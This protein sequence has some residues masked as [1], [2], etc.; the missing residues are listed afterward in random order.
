SVSSITSAEL[1]DPATGIW[2]DTGSLDTSRS[3]HTATLLPNGK[4][5]YAGG[6]N[7]SVLASAE[8]YDPA[9]GTWTATGSLATS[10]YGHTATLLLNGKVLVAGGGSSGPY[11]ASA[12]LYDPA[13]STWSATGSLAATRYDHTATLL[14][15]GKVLVAGGYNGSYLASAALYDPASGTWTSTGSLTNARRNHTATLLPDGK[16]LVAAGKNSNS[17][18]LASAELYDP[19]TGIW[20][21]T[22]SLAS[23]RG[24]H[25]A[26]LLS[27]DKVLVAGGYNTSSLDSAELYDPGTGTWTTTGSL[28][29]A[30][31]VHTATLLPNGKVL[32][33]G[34]G[35]GNLASAELYDPVTGT[36]STTSSLAIGRSKHTATL[37]PDG[38][39]LIAAGNDSFGAVASAELY[40]VGL[41]FSG[42]SRTVIGS[43]S[44]DAAGKLVLTGAG[45]LGISS[46]SGGNGSQ[47][48]PTNYPVLQLRR[49][50]NDQCAYLPYDPSVNV[51]ATSLR[52]LPV[53]A[54]PGYALATVFTNGIPSASAMV[55]Y[56]LPTVPDIALEAPTGTVVT[57]GSG[58]LAYGSIAPGQT[59]DLN[60]TVRNSG[61]AVLTAITATLI[62]PDAGQF[63]L[64]STPPASIVAGASAEVTLRFSP[65]SLGAK[66]AALSIASNDPD[67]NPFTLALTGTANNAPSDL[68]LS[69]TSVVESAPAN[70]TVGTFSSTDLDAGD[71]FTYSLVSG[72]GSND[73]AA[74]TISGAAL[75]INN[76]PV[77]ATQSSY[78]IRIR[79][80]DSGGLFFEKSFN[81]T[82]TASAVVFV[83]WATSAGLTGVNAEFSAIPFNDGVENLI[84]YAF[85]MNA[86]GPDVGVL[87]TGGL[88][89][90][91]QILVDTSGAEPV[92]KVEFLRR[93]GSG[94][95]YTPQRSTTLGNFVNMTGTQTVTYIDAQWERVSVEE[96][97]PPATA[98]SAFA[99]VQVSLP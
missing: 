89:G 51:S 76:T 47:D 39:L 66:T 83:D 85:N 86:A 63:A 9:T 7:G 69:A 56:S 82:V 29:A 6:Y 38:K 40:D 79:S 88:S 41:G 55:S 45:F 46:A 98:P 72:S 84:K 20:T 50:D 91:P 18:Y 5:L 23:T 35:N 75:K 64:V 54:F 99:R 15:N 67:E 65:T 34:G 12:E 37:L 62:G 77:L 57:N 11:L 16:V 92:L 4:V 70:T 61:S 13:T 48:S 8:L 53:A 81:I 95:I 73:N 36:F 96:P 22:T 2:T 14:P 49:L 27:N 28:G 94:L 59:K 30:R 10:R 44:F 78:A 3:S 33:A 74:F 24:F 68:M 31:G 58:S 32:V 87:T 90:L 1:Y 43:A 25:T 80:T 71:S 97:A 21:A 60:V 19:A 26:T 52:T 17:G 42:A 93:K